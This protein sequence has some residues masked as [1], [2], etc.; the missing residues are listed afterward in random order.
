MHILNK[1]CFTI[2]SIV[3]HVWAVEVHGFKCLPACDFSTL[4]KFGP[5]GCLCIAFGPWITQSIYFFLSIAFGDGISQGIH[6]FLLLVEDTAC[7]CVMF[8]LAI[9][10][11]SS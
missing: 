6:C 9:S 8:P 11:A 2:S 5:H 10:I 4:G 1:V 7:H 3:F